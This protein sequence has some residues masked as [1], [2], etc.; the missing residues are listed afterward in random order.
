MSHHSLPHPDLRRG[1]GDSPPWITRGQGGH[2]QTW[3]FVFIDI[4]ALFRQFRVGGSRRPPM[5]GICDV[6][7]RHVRESGPVWPICAFGASQTFKS[8][9]SASP[10][11]LFDLMLCFHRHSRFVR[12]F[13]N[14]TN[15]VSR[16][17]TKCTKSAK[18]HPPPHLRREPEDSPPRIRR[19]PG[20]SIS[21]PILCFHRHSGFVPEILAAPTS[22]GL[23]DH[24]RLGCS[25]AL[26]LTSRRF[27]FFA[28]PETTIP[29]FAT[30]RPNSSLS[31]C[32]CQETGSP[33]WCQ[34][35][36]GAARRCHSTS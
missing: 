31:S 34:F 2:F 35:D 26:K 5:S 10:P 4:L 27:S 23:T 24:G 19:D 8:A 28:V 12:R 20:W 33:S 15:P 16:Q 29:K 32:A 1:A 13:F 22:G 9:V 14:V 18:S 25:P 7:K 17:G 11:R 21:I 6:P 36:V 3:S 30:P